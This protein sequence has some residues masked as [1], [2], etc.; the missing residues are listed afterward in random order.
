MPLDPL[1]DNEWLG[2][3]MTHLAKSGAAVRARDN[4]RLKVL[5]DALPRSWRNVP[6]EYDITYD[7]PGNKIRGYRY[8]DMMTTCVWVAICNEFLTVKSM[9]ECIEKGPTEEGMRILEQTAEASMDKYLQRKTPLLNYPQRLIVLPGS[10]L[11]QR[12]ALDMERMKRLVGEGAIIKPHPITNR[13]DFFKLKQIFGDQAV[14]DPSVAL[15]P[16]IRNARAI[17]VGANSEAGIA[18]MMYGKEY[19]IIGPKNVFGEKT[20]AI[21]PTYITFYKALDQAAAGHLS[22]KEKLGALFSY[23]ES[24]LVSI[25]HSNPKE[26]FEAFFHQYDKYEHGR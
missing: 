25:F 19:A 12:R 21:S 15:F 7:T 10:N 23:P 20:Q 4:D 26:R 17:W 13:L 3:A 5:G 9:I 6:V 22:P 8:T 24:G 16:L 14:L 2:D 11:I 18:A 1:A